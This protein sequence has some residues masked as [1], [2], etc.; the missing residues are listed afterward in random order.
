MRLLEDNL[1]LQFHGD[2]VVELLP[3]KFLVTIPIQGC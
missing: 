2:V 1:P 3:N